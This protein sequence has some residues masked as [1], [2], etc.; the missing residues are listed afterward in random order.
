[1]K[2]NPAT[3]LWSLLISGSLSSCAPEQLRHVKSPAASTP[4]GAFTKHL[5]VNGEK[6]QGKLLEDLLVSIAND[7]RY[8]YEQRRRCILTFF[9]LYRRHPRRISDLAAILDHPTWVRSEDITEILALTGGIPVEIAPNGTV[10]LV[11]IFPE[12]ERHQSGIFF[13]FVERVSAEVFY[14]L[15]RGAR[16]APTSLD[17][18]IA[19]IG[20]FE[21]GVPDRDIDA[22]VSWLLHHEALLQRDAG[23]VREGSG[24][25]YSQ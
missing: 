24:P 13:R 20:V 21:Q 8:S 6:G 11:T 15:M 23:R 17:P 1:M 25:N 12:S 3:F 16:S 19:E 14:G 2:A 22:L 18:Q 4:P 10:I 5:T 9:R 7:S